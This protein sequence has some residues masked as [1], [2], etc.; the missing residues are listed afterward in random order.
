MTVRQAVGTIYLIAICCGGVAVAALLL[1][2]VDL[3]YV[4]L[5]LLGLAGLVALIGL[6]RVDL[7]DTGQVERS[8]NRIRITGFRLRDKSMVH[9]VG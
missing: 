3:L 6:E 1:P 7:A 5:V 8:R 4:I 9:R 2:S